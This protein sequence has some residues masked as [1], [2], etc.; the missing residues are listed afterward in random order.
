MKSGRK[1]AKRKVHGALAQQIWPEGGPRLVG[2]QAQRATRGEGLWRR[3]RNSPPGEHGVHVIPHAGSLPSRNSV[4]VGGW[5][6]P[7]ARSVRGGARTRR[8][9]QCGGQVLP[10]FPSL[11]SALCNMGASLRAT[12]GDTCRAG[13]GRADTTCHQSPALCSVHSRDRAFRGEVSLRRQRQLRR[14]GGS[15]VAV[16]KCPLDRPRTGRVGQSVEL[17]NLKLILDKFPTFK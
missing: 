3:S 10:L 5:H 15:G 16:T 11:A 4:L 7:M 17:P 8:A 1:S 13:V 9:A 12:S 14:L 6:E 2:C